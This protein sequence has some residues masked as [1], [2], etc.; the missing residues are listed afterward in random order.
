MN[1]L[2]IYNAVIEDE[3]DG[4]TAIS[5]VDYPAVE[6]NFICFSKNK[7]P[8]IFSIE[9]EEEHI[10]T[11]VLMLCDTPIYRRNGDFEY[12]INFSKDT[13]KQMSV[14]LLKDGSFK[15]ISFQHNGE[16]LPQGCIEMIELFIKNDTKGISPNFVENIPDGSLMVSFKVNDDE[17]W[18]ECKNGDF[19]N[20]FS[21]EGFFDVEEK[22]FNNHKKNNIINMSK[23]KDLFK[24][25]LTAFGAVQTAEGTLHYDGDED[26]KAGMEVYGEDGEAAKDGEYHTEDGKTIK[27]ENGVV[28]EIVDA[29]A[30]VADEEVE[31]E[32]EEETVEETTEEIVEEPEV[33]EI[34]EIKKEIED[35]KKAIEEIKE[36]L[37]E[38]AAET[39]EETFNAVTKKTNK[40]Q[41]LG[42]ALRNLK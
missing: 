42:E 8:Q 16:L 23:I 9:N 6:S 14:K 38:P 36:M 28:V 33:D 34:A 20:G 11:G 17:I 31:V 2:P 12:Y 22:K 1:N 41:K 3:M 39:V 40:Y 5:L 21:L 25:L 4:I 27:V 32:A 13:I 19:L 15:N 29:E 7:K 30:E 26:L 18:N 37:K 35:L 24:K 10:I